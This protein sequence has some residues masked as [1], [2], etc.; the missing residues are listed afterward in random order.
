MPKAAAFGLRTSGEIP[1]PETTKGGAC[2]YGGIFDGDGPWLR[3]YRD[4]QRSARPADK[5][6]C[7]RVRDESPQTHSKM[8]L[9]P[10]VPA[11]GAELE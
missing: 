11:S 2:R 1:T 4:P 7:K 6:R 9:E 10:S 5:A 8:L 3:A